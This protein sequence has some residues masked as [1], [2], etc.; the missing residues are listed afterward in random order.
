MLQFLCI[1]NYLNEWDEIIDNTN[2][3]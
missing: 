1:N 2:V 3:N